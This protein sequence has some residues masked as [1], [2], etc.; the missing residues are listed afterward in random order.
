MVFGGDLSKKSTRQ[1]CY[2][3]ASAS[4]SCGVWCGRWWFRTDHLDAGEHQHWGANFIS[5][6]PV[7]PVADGPVW[8]GPP[9]CAVGVH[10]ITI[11][12]LWKTIAGRTD[13]VS[14]LWQYLMN[15][16]CY[17]RCFE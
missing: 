1:E 14:S 17:G 15:S 2:Q 7:F 9:C 4:E 5:P 12:D 16:L 11:F 6:F 8:S 3:L 10:F 13:G